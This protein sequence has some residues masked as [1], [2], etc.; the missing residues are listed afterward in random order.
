MPVPMPGML[1][2]SYYPFEEVD[3]L[4]IQLLPE[5]IMS[6]TTLLGMNVSK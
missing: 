4:Q 2:L 6:V 1:D 5:I 3:T